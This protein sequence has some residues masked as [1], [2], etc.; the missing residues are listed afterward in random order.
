[1][2]SLKCRRAAALRCA[3]AW[4]I[5]PNLSFFLFPVY[6][7]AVYCSVAI[8]RYIVHCTTCTIVFARL[9]DVHYIHTSN[10]HTYHHCHTVRSDEKGEN[11]DSDHDEAKEKYFF[12]TSSVR[13][14]KNLSIYRERDN[15]AGP[16]EQERFLSGVIKLE[17]SCCTVR[18]QHMHIYNPRTH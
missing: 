2:T 16:N 7:A 8:Y 18:R 4:P 6:S 3:A 11:D 14:S 17:S 5:W 13:V 12:P 10:M 1:M 15:R 9:V